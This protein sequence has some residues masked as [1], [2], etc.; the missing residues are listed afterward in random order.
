MQTRSIIGCIGVITIL[1][2]LTSMLASATET[3][4][5]VRSKTLLTLHWTDAQGAASKTRLTLQDLDSLPQT[6]RTLELP[7][8]LGMKGSHSWQGVSIS[9]LIKLSGRSAKSV[10]V[11]ALNG[12][13][14]SVPLD[15]L[16]NYDPL[17]AYRR[18][19]KNLSIREKGPIILI[20]PFDRF[21]VLN[22]QTYINRSVWQI[23]EIHIE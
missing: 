10:R 21:K 2:L 4:L 1:T 22:Q 20:Y 5:P 17:V 15:D 12:Y 14:A 13:Y 8:S 3:P 7:E 18:D 16:K 23:N 6:T 11:V 9:E 19:G